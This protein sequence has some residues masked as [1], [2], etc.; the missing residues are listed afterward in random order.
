MGSEMCIRDSA[1]TVACTNASDGNKI[2]LPCRKLLALVRS[3]KLSKAEKLGEAGFKLQTTDVEDLLNTFQPPKTASE[4]R[5][6][7]SAICTLANLPQYKLDAPR[8]GTQDALVIITAMTDE[9]FVIEA[10][11][12]LTKEESAQVKESLIS[13]LYQAMHIHA[14]DRKRVVEWTDGS[15]PLNSS[16]C[17]RLGS[18]PTDAPLPEP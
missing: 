2:F 4:K 3:S 8:G 13:L 9:A 14:R 10:V 1:F 11:H 18:A 15:S 5:H 16:K 7:L 12:C 17:R 6:T